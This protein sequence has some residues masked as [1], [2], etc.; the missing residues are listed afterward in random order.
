MD[1]NVDISQCGA[2]FAR[3]EEYCDV[4][5]SCPLCLTD[6]TGRIDGNYPSCTS[7]NDY[8]TCNRSRV[9]LFSCATNG[10]VWDAFI[11]KCVPPPSPSCSLVKCVSSCMGLADG[12]YHSCFGCNLYMECRNGRD[13][14]MTCKPGEEFNA[15]SGN[16]AEGLSPTCARAIKREVD[17]LSG[18]APAD[19]YF[20]ADDMNV[21]ERRELYLKLRK[22]AGVAAEFNREEEDVFGLNE[23][24]KAT[25]D[26][27]VT[28]KKGDDKTTTTKEDKM[29]D[30]KG[31]N[32]AEI[33]DDEMTDNEED[34]KVTIKEDT[35]TK[36]KNGKK[37]G[38]SCRS[39][40]SGVGPGMHQSCMGCRYYLVC[41]KH[42]VARQVK[43]PRNKF[44][45]DK[46][47]KCKKHSRTC[48]GRT[49]VVA[50]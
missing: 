26:D 36:E 48:K 29:T 40:C 10:Y 19:N 50:E 45:D 12:R 31:D 11:R 35:M 15:H 14:E 5:A 6:C 20:L 27:E 17:F 37:E 8:V 16:C 24:I 39:D 13:T 22:Q 1:E 47:K 44:W 4:R 18:D 38:H 9:A 32:K 43:C 23:D 30:N 2:G 21:E 25:K 3:E 7:C 49:D 46:R 33:T 28:K 41:T 42:G 34:E